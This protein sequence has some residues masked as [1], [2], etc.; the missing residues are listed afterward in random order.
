MMD[1]AARIRKVGLLV[2]RHGKSKE[3]VAEV[4]CSECGK[5]IRS[6]DDMTTIGWVRTKRGT[7]MFFHERCRRKKDEDE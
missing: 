4:Y 6:D 2:K 1:I 7:E 3:T 5:A